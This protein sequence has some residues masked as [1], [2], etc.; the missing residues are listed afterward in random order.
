M[1]EFVELASSNVAS[2]YL[3]SRKL[4]VTLSPLHVDGVIAKELVNVGD[5]I[6]AEKPLCFLQAIPNAQDVVVC[7]GCQTV[8]GSLDIH[9]GILSKTVSRENITSPE[10]ITPCR[11]KCG[12]LYCSGT[13]KETFPEYHLV[14][15]LLLC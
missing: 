12:V 15:M 7:G 13:S 8:L 5:V 1:S 2:S 4:E 11:A 6:Y 14:N 10:G 3:C 9:V